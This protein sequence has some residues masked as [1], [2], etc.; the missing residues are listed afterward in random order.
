[1]N[2]GV[3]LFDMMLWLFGPMNELEIH[4]REPNRV[5]GMMELKHANVR[6]FLS[7][8][9]TDLPE[10]VRNEG[11]HAYRSLVMDGNAIEFSN[12]FQNLHTKVYQEV[13][14]GRGHDINDARASIEL[15]YRVRTQRVVP[16]RDSVH[17][18]LQIA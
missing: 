8:D 16:P 6:W 14:A 9:E 4:V 5:S 7:I 15:A 1:M 10:Q 17:P 12:G 13:F 11:G 3:H 2:I 18:K